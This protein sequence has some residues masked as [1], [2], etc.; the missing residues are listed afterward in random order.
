[1]KYEDR[2]QVVVAELKQRGMYEKVVRQIGDENYA[3]FKDDDD[4]FFL[5]FQNN[6]NPDDNGWAWL[7]FE[8]HD[9]DELRR[10]KLEGMFDNFTDIHGVKAL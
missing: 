5:H 7:Q 2:D 3:I 10:R 6:P 4:N 1:M 8:E 9:S